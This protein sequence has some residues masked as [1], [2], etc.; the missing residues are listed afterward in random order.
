MKLYWFLPVLFLTGCRT[1]FYDL[2]YDRIRLGWLETEEVHEND[3]YYR[4]ETTKG[5]EFRWLPEWPTMN[6]YL[7][8]SYWL[9]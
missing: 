7:S 4:V 3:S 8:W 9:K 6:N 1:S 2:S 5:V